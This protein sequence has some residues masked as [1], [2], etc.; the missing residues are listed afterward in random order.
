MF[1]R[2]GKNI[3][4]DIIHRILYIYCP[5]WRET[6][7]FVPHPK[8][9][10]RLRDTILL[11][12]FEYMIF[13]SPDSLGNCLLYRKLKHDVIQR[14]AFCSL[15]ETWQGKTTSGGRHDDLFSLHVTSLDQSYFL[16]VISIIWGIIIQFVVLDNSGIS[17]YD[18]CYHNVNRTACLLVQNSSVLE[19]MS[20][21][22][23]GDECTYM[24]STIVSQVPLYFQIG[25]TPLS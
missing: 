14:R 12:R 23:L 10:C 8:N 6:W 21:G 16:C 3:L 5:V 24:N 20:R 18:H 15:H 19:H 17:G 2:K 7:R 11:M 13:M 25:K 4:I 22:Q 1:G 9:S